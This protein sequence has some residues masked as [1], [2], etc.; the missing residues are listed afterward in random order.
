[1]QK[2]TLYYDG[3]C[4]LCNAEISTLEGLCDDSLNLVDVH[5]LD[6]SAENA[7]QMLKL[8]HYQTSEGE[9]LVGLDANVAAWQH[10]RWGFLFKPLRWPLIG[11]IADLIYAYWAERRFKRLYPAGVPSQNKTCN[12]A[13][14]DETPAR[15]LR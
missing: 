9:T 2:E 12:T 5:G 4:P 11:Q 7:E 3:A 14:S 1:M 6:V 15:M 8:L 13:T 10:T